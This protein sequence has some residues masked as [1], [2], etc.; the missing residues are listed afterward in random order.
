M[1]AIMRLDGV[2]KDFGGGGFLPG[3]KR[4]RVRAVADVDLAVRQGATL[5]IVGE[6]GCGKTTLA[7]MLVRLEHPSRGAVFHDDRDIAGLRGQALRQF[8]K[9]VQFVFQDPLTS[10]NPRK[11][12]RQILELPL[13]RLRGLRKRE[14]QQR[15]GE[16]A[17]DVGLRTE[18]LDRY[19][20]ELSGGQSQRVGIARA[21]AAEPAVIVLDEPVSALDVSIQAQVLNLLERLKGR[22]G[23]TYV[24]ISHDL[25]VVEKLADTVAVME[26]GEVVEQGP[27]ADIF[28]RPAHPYT[29]LLLS[30]VPRLEG[31]TAD[32]SRTRP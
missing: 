5:G 24:F 18:F 9:E 2:G 30:S 4:P 11:K 31:G 12:V 16:L 17:D 27:A 1:T 15:V 7:R 10:L 32:G 13:R 25:A 22:H 23:L 26:A 20:H 8:R 29:R 6:S 14:L 19:P 3:R 28:R 21:L